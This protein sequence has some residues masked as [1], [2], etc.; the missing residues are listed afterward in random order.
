MLLFSPTKSLTLNTN[1]PGLPTYFYCGLSACFCICLCLQKCVGMRVVKLIKFCDEI[2]QWFSICVYLTCSTFDLSQAQ[3][4]TMTL[5]Q[6]SLAA[7]LHSHIQ[8]CTLGL[9]L[10][11]T[12]AFS[13]S[14][15]IYNRHLHSHLPSTSVPGFKNHCCKSPMFIPL[16]LL[17][18]LLEVFISD[19]QNSKLCFLINL[20]NHVIVLNTN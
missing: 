19:I 1:Q 3:Y 14:D 13:A 9:A 4:K 2:C 16:C 18:I 15:V 6:K 17:Y 5:Y 20:V 12:C 11:G 7:D 10:S 8:A